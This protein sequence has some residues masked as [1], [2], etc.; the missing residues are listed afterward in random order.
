MRNEIF[1]ARNYFDLPGQT[2]KY[3]RNDFGGTIG[4]PFYI[5]G[6]YERS[7]SK[8]YFFFSEEVRREESPPQFP[9]NHAL[10]SNAERA[11]I[12]NDVC[13]TSGAVAVG[14]GFLFKR[15]AY[16]DCPV[17][18]FTGTAGNVVGYPNNTVPVTSFAKSILNTGLIP[19]ANATTGCDSTIGSCYNTTVSPY[20]P[21]GM[22][23]CFGSTRT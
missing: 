10:P 23:S 9:F 17:Y 14:G 11:G 12:F 22:K 20:P 15:R 7:K 13:P 8:T 4:G 5:P 6:I 1:N 21:T 3:R 18:N 19:Q 16:P 2:P